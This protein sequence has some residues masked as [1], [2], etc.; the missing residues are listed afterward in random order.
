M[1]KGKLIALGTPRE[2]VASLGAEHVVEFAMADGGAAR[3]PAAVGA[4]RRARCA[5][6]RR[7]SCTCS[8]SE[9]HLTVPALLDFLRQRT[10]TLSQLATHSAT[11]EDV[12]VSLTG[13]HLRD[14]LSRA[15]SAG[16]ADLARFREFLREPEALFW[17]FAFPVIMTC[18]LGV[19]FRSRGAEPV[20][21]GVVEQAGAEAIADRAR[22]ERRLHRAALPA[23]EVERAAARRPRAGGRRARHAAGVSLRRGARREPGGAARGGRGA[24]A[25]RGTHGCVQAVEQPMQTVGSRYI[26]WLVPGLLGM[27]IMGTG[28]W[29]VGFVDRQRARARSC[30]SGWWRRRCRA[31]YLLSHGASAG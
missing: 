4:A 7:R 10:L 13:R 21:V 6:R 24:A 5:A 12:F 22:A 1:D 27:N 19:A 9:L 18:A 17:V 29:G 26:D 30:S 8:T 11:L 28:M 2:L 25:R 23:D 20:I 14:E 3:R 16:R 31:H 15:A